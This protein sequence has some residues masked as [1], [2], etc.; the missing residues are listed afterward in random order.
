MMTMNFT[1]HDLY[2]AGFL[3]ASGFQLTGNSRV[4]NKVEFCYE[5]T[6]KLL[7]LVDD[8]YNMNATINPL[9]L[10]SQ[11]KIL[12]NILYQKNYTYT[13]Y[14]NTINHQSRKGS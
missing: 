11:L 10:S 2:L 4:G 1:T 14:D 6:D 9:L 8:Y 3:N 7:Q 5:Q 12:K 13:N